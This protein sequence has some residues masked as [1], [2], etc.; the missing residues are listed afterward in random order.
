MVDRLRQAMARMRRQPSQPPTDA[1]TPCTCGHAKGEHYM[2][3]A[4]THANPEWSPVTCITNQCE[5]E[6]FVA[7]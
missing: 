4:S 2:T 7:A 5:C 6:G 1:A 3:Y